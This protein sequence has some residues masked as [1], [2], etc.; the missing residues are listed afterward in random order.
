MKVYEHQLRELERRVDGLSTEGNVNAFSSKVSPYR[1]YEVGLYTTMD[2]TL[3]VGRHVRSYL[4][5]I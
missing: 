5:N 3:V 1:A 2:D 4:S